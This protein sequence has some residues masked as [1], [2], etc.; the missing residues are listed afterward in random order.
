M[1]GTML[2]TDDNP[3]SWVPIS[4]FPLNMI[5][6][7]MR[8]IVPKIQPL[9]DL[10]SEIYARVSPTAVRQRGAVCRMTKKKSSQNR[11]GRSKGILVYHESSFPFSI[12]RIG[13]KH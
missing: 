8:C 3:C 10:L 2:Q 1:H 11:R 7:L 12:D 13:R 6:T 4:F 5:G 9:A